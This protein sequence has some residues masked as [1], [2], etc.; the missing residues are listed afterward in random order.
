VSSERRVQY[1]AIV[2]QSRA[3]LR[4]R[5][6][7]VVIFP[8]V[9]VFAA[10]FVPLR[11]AADGIGGYLDFGYSNSTLDSKDILGNSS[12]TDSNVYSQRY[13]LGL[14]KSLFPYLRL[15]AGGLYDQA[16]SSATTNGAKT[17]S[18]QI[19]FQPTVDLTLRSPV[20]TAGVRYTRQE[21]TTKSQGAP[22][23]TN[24]N[25]SYAGTLGLKP[26]DT[27][28]PTLDL[29][30][31]RSRLYDKEHLSRDTVND[32]AALTMNYMPTNNF[33]LQYRPTYN[34][35]TDKLT[36]LETKRLDQ[37]GRIEYGNS[38]FRNRVSFNTSYNV[39]YN[40]LRTSASGTG[41]VDINVVPFSGLSVI[42]DTPL[43]GA[44]SQNPALIDGNLTASAGINIGLPPVGG[45]TRE[46]NIGL[47]FSLA[48]DV[49]TLYV[50]VD[51]SLPS[52]ISSSFAWDIYTSTDNLTWSLYTTVSPALFGT[53]DNRFEISFST[54]HTRYIKL[55]VKPLSPVVQ[56]AAGFANIFVTEI[57]A[58]SRK[59]AEQ[60]QRKSTSS[61]QIFN[62]DGKVLLLT[63][64]NLYYNLSY[65]LVRSE[66]FSQQRWALSNTLTA[67]HRF[68]R[69]FSGSARGGREDFY[70]PT[71]FGFDYVADLSLEAVPLPTLRHNLI[72]SGRF[73][74][75]ISG[76]TNMNSLFLYNNAHV[77]TGVDLMASGG[78][79]FQDKPAG[80]H[81]KST[82][83]NA[84]LNLQPHPTLNLS[85]YHDSLTTL[86]YG[87][88]T[89]E[90][91]QKTNRTDETA[92]YHPIETLYLVVALS[93]IEYPEKTRRSQ[94][95]SVNWSPFF[96]GNLQFSMA[97]T[98]SLDSEN[99]T[100]VRTWSPSLTWKINRT[101]YL[102]ASY[103]VSQGK[104]DDGTS[105]S[106]LFSTNLR[107]Y[108]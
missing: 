63:N 90:R 59:P 3:L 22:T 9:L 107:V 32:Y 105:D 54:I 17:T 80:V 4:S 18:T 6:N 101:S 95:Y 68:N 58:L 74:E 47:D 29:R 31:G 23:S 42:D 71:N 56:G 25:E 103:Q 39:S 57:Q 65:F 67:T 83:W 84:G 5:V 102:A 24:I 82:D 75:D 77:Y 52:E 85:F 55:V 88:G 89:V 86:S 69:V 64:P 7:L 14:T 43:D 108:F 11:A 73:G 106:K 104:S 53:F 94:S 98:E 16:D 72:Y 20:Y 100:R 26:L 78:M 10:L 34:V 30:V 41:I 15:Y 61:T 45:D 66:P 35:T 13:N 38:F 93:T 37:V 49:N 60:L 99:N 87:G 97:Y 1:V 46:R 91:T 40:E 62:F 81:V 96:G 50:W 76:R 70:D 2:P 33:S 51:K 27:E 44:L 92:S 36:G 8:A 21:E 28:L 48:K 19:R 12:R 79:T